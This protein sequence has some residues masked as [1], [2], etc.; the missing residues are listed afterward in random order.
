MGVAVN[1]LVLEDRVGSFK[2][3][4]QLNV[5]QAT[6][7]RHV[8]K[9]RADPTH[10]IVKRLGPIICVFTPEQEAEIKII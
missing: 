5:L 4:R 6:F 7:W 9:T 1:N 8:A 10:V 3:A 2:A